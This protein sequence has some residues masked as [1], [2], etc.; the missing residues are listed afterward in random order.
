M[1]SRDLKAALGA[2]VL[3][4][5]LFGAYALTLADPLA[6]QTATS[7]VADATADEVDSPTSDQLATL[8]ADRVQIEDQNRLVAQGNVEMYYRSNRLIATR[9]IYDQAQDKLI[10][11]GPI[12]LE[13]PGQTGSIIVASQ[14]ELSPDLRNGVLLSAR[15]VMARELQLAA[16]SIE[17][18]DGRLTVMKQVVASS[19]EV[20]I[21][22][23]TPLWEIRARKVVHDAQSRQIV[24]Y[25]A[26]FRAAGVPI[27]YLPRLR[28][29][30]PGVKRMSGFLR[31]SFRTTSGL[32]AG[33]KLPYFFALGPSRD[34]TV[35]PYVSAARTA[36]LGLRYR[37]AYNWGDLTLEGA[38]SDDD[39]IPNETRGY[40]FGDLSA[41]LP[42]DFKLGVQLR[43]VSDSSY[44]LNY[45][46]SDEDR[47]WSGITLERVRAGEMITAKFG[48]THSLRD[49]ESNTTDPMLS[50]TAQWVRSFRPA[51]IGGLATVRFSTLAARRA[52]DSTLDS[53]LDGVPDGRDMLRGSFTANWQRNWLLPGGVLGGI[54]AQYAA[55]IIQ[56]ASDPSYDS[57]ILRDQPTL[58]TELRWPWVKSSTR[59]SYVIEPIAQ[60]VWAPNTLTASPDEDSLLPEFDEGNLFSLSR[61]PGEDMRE[62]G[63][64]ANLGV[65]WTR[66]DASGW[67]LG[68]LAGRIFRQR[69]L[70]QFETGSALAGVQSDWLVSTQLSTSKGLT[71][72]NRA[73]FDDDL[74][75]SREEMRVAWAADRYQVSAGYLWVD[76]A[77]DS[78]LD[79]DLSELTLDTEWKWANGWQ[80]SFSTRY[81]FTAQR[82]A[83]AKLGL[84]Y[85][86]ECVLV[87]LSLSRRF[88]SSTS[89]SPETDFGLSV[90]LVGFGSAQGGAVRRMCAR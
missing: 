21:T 70:S 47:L 79:T 76:A 90:Q 63:L 7:A 4:G 75:F 36:T 26:Q 77:S 46:I 37:E 12:R 62:T 48:N 31:P 88:T 49:G 74:S 1:R 8:L 84:Q 42:D 71:W 5:G 64:R 66:Y 78:S 3:G 68:V 85:T 89:V 2:L 54:E 73:L 41:R 20:C 43:L 52:S 50:G 59:A 65:S 14:A 16:A 39:I 15:M 61:F 83:R 80:S 56:T 87:D 30:E 24:F 25:D 58:A 44:L 32:G 28:M 18:K 29:P 38:V 40:L 67:S 19:C 6:A 34:L 13:Q 45:D 17:R 82:A 11:E 60:I 35:T 10:I 9:V 72:T 55:D 57:T 81:D 86:N 69:D 27:A 51:S 23:P 53:D 33:I 22:D